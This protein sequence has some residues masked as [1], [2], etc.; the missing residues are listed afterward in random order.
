M[1]IVID[2]QGAQAA[3]RNRGIGG[4]SL[5]LALAL[6]KN[7]GE[8]EILL[9]LNA[10]FPE[11]IEP[12]R[13]TFDKLLPQENIR[14]LQTPTH[15]AA[16]IAGNAKRRK[17]AELIR[18]AFLY[19]LRPDFVLTLSLFEG[20]SDDAVTSVGACGNLPTAVVLYDLIPLIHRA[21]YLD[22]APIC[23]AWYMEKLDHLRRADLLLSISASS[24]REAENH[25]GF[26]SG[27]IVNISGDC[28]AAFR[29]QVVTAECRRQL[30]ADHGIERPFVMYTGGMD[31]RKNI[32]GL[33]QAYSALPPELRAAHQL[34]VVCAASTEELRRLESLALQQGLAQ[35]DFIMTGF[36]PEPKLVTLYNACKLFVF[37]S[38]HEGL[39]LPVLEA[40]RCGKAVLAGNNSSLPEVVGRD[41]ALFDAGDPADIAAKMAAVLQDETKRQSLEAHSLLYAQ[42]FSWEASA[43]R[44]L[45]ALVSIHARSWARPPGSAHAL[46]QPD[47]SS[48]GQGFEPASVQ[49]GENTTEAKSIAVNGTPTSRRPRLAY[50]SPLPP[51][52]SGI[53]DYSAELLPVL[54][55]W[56]EIEV[57]VAQAKVTHPWILE[58]CPIRSVEWFCAHAGEFE[59]VLYHFGNSSFHR[60]LFAL[61]E[62]IPG[63]I[64]LHDFFLSGIQA[65]RA[66]LPDTPH[67]WTQALYESHGYLAVLE[68]YLEK[69]VS[70]VIWRY[71]ANLPVLQSALGVIVHSEHARRLAGQWYGDQ[72]GRDWSVVPHLREAPS[73]ADRDRDLARHSLG[74]APEDFLVC[75]FGF[76]GTTKLNERLLD[77]WRASPLAGDKRAYLV[78]VGDQRNEYGRRIERKIR[79]SGLGKQ[80]SVTGRVD[81]TV[82][83]R[84]LAAADVGVQLRSRSRGETSGTVLDCLNY[85]LA[86]IVNAHGSQADLDPGSVWMLPD[87]FENRELSRA[88]LTMRDD[89]ER[90]R[91]L[92]E[93]GRAVVASRH[94]PR[95]CAKKYAEAIE[96]VYAP[97]QGGAPGLV[98]EL[99]GA[100]AGTEALAPWPALLAMNFPPAP[101]ARQLLV[102]VSELV[103]RDAKSGIQR[104]TR[105]VLREWLLN[106]APNG[107]RVEAV[108]A[109]P[110]SAG[111]FYARRFTCRFLGVPDDW[112]ED[113]P[114]EA[115]VG[116]VFLGLDLQP[117]VI[118]A[119]A[120]HLEKWRNQGVRV[121]FVVYDLLPVLHPQF[122]VAGA[123]EAHQSWLTTVCRFDAVFCISQSVTDELERWRAEFGP[124]R[125][126]P[127]G[128]E[129]FHLGSDIVASVPSQ[130]LPPG[131]ETVLDQMS[132]RKSF[133]MVGTLEPRKGHAEVLGA[134]ERLW[135]EGHDLPL[136][137]VGRQGWMVEALVRRLVLHPEK[138]WRLFWLADVSDEYLERLYA[139]ATCLIAA[140]YAEGFGLPLIEAAQHGLPVIARDIPV[141][142]EVA[143]DHACYFSD[144]LAATLT[145]W[146]LLHEAGQHPRTEAMLWRSWRESAARLWQLATTSAPVPAQDG[147]MARELPLADAST[148]PPSPAPG[149]M[150]LPL[151]RAA[152]LMIQSPWLLD[153]CIWLLGY[154]PGLR[155]RIRRIMSR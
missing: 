33:I 147:R 60:H 24:G 143:G 131:A 123:K 42:R 11:T 95:Q 23:A 7:R 118:P 135:A 5:S 153:R 140:S 108:Y 58:H 20:L 50:L 115:W 89:P 141:F 35:G 76:L 136:V 93:A 117:Q 112:A 36:V 101:R 40:M 134:F 51:E 59:R 12:I 75:S 144:D 39:G 97:A 21:L 46:P 37:P 128:M 47:D 125:M 45:A 94:D 15:L 9:A 10:G 3:S 13:A 122:F 72:A 87:A 31:H 120:E 79:M 130:S 82:F 129:W 41:D 67:A 137:I 96:R 148:L 18:E 19:A 17:A 48:A 66:T 113:A 149:W 2:L 74:L 86:T 63:V 98:P 34:V 110:Q 126:R 91:A 8:H 56:Y 70:E 53:S 103:V 107:W 111:Y 28:G 1:R 78:F 25:L 104:V 80:V 62:Q 26:P 65:D 88:L 139:A 124:V 127:L 64:A 155:E 102:D 152:G 85:G 151:R 49:D 71:P 109:T 121:C 119:Q 54:S 92:G 57:V 32:E 90:R 146:L 99:L 83:R 100:L 84:Y 43:R 55:E 154:F 142:R 22:N 38:W 6:A 14:V 116:D 145:Q 77:A 61:L 4:Y 29:P 30:Q 52:A 69:N 27:K 133:L 73:G 138:N 106:P 114:A 81:Q 105:A 16:Q 68:H 150:S 44:A 132:A